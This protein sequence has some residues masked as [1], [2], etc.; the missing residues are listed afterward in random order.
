MLLPVSQRLKRAYLTSY[1]IHLVQQ[2]LTYLSVALSDK[3][4]DNFCGNLRQKSWQ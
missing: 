3:L 1:V 2:K 4:R